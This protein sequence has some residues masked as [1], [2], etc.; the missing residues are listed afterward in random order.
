[1]AVAQTRR[2][3]QVDR[4]AETRATLIRATIDLLQMVGFAGTTTAL[5]AKR[6]GVTT[7]ALHHHFATKDELMF[8]VLDH[9]SERVRERLEEEEHLSSGGTLHISDLVRRV[10]NGEIDPSFVV[11][12]RLGLED[13]PQAFETFKR[14]HGPNEHGE[15]CPCCRVVLKPGLTKADTVKKEVNA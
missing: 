13:T 9:A 14:K 6:S 12:H 10:E 1:M 5:I 8:G 7:G 15:D 3:S 4:S 2:R 11:T